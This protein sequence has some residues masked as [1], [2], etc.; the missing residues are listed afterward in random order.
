MYGNKILFFELGFEQSLA[1]LLSVLLLNG[2]L[3]IRIKYGSM[4][5]THVTTR[6]YK[7]AYG[8]LLLAIS[9]TLGL[10]FLTNIYYRDDFH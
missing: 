5:V 1:L 8:Y 2:F 6:P 9:Q 7:F 3:H 4:V 10:I